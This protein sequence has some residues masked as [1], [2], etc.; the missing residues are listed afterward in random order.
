MTLLVECFSRMHTE[1]AGSR[2]QLVVWSSCTHHACSEQLGKRKLKKS[3][4]YS[5]LYQT[6]QSS[7]AVGRQRIYDLKHAQGFYSGPA[8]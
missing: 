1:A 2:L 6:V 4:G 8:E 5:Y 3:Y 7:T